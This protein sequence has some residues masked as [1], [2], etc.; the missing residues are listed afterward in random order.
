[1]S[2][3]L[4]LLLILGFVMLIWYSTRLLRAIKRERWPIYLDELESLL[5]QGT[6]QGDLKLQP[7][8]DEEVLLCLRRVC[9]KLDGMDKSTFMT[10]MKLDFGMINRYRPWIYKLLTEEMEIDC[11]ESKTSIGQESSD[12]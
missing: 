5:K 9:K 8:S 4:I 2:K 1:M 6:S 7:A 11:Q 3:Q 12:E 10:S